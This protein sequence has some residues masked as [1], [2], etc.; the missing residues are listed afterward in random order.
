MVFQCL[1]QT[2]VNFNATTAHM[3]VNLTFLAM[4]FL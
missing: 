3:H 1:L 2:I 4:F